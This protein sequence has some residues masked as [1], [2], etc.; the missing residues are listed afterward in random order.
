MEI[1]KVRD[2]QVGISQYYQIPFDED[3]LNPDQW[4]YEQQQQKLAELL[5]QSVQRRLIADVPLGTF[6]SGGGKNTM[7]DVQMVPHV[8]VFP[9]RELRPFFAQ[10]AYFLL[11]PLPFRG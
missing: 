4:H 9:E 1:S 10:A 8:R 6:L 7:L 5:E 3:H 11:F 2:P